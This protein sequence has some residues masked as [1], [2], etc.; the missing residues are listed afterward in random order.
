MRILGL[1]KLT[2]ATLVMAMGSVPA[3]AQERAGAEVT[4]GTIDEVVVTAQ[5]REERLLDVPISISVI[6]GEALDQ[7]SA[8]GANEIL[9]RIPGVAAVEGYSAGGTLVTVRGV[10]GGSALANGSSPI[11][12]YLDDVPFGLV[13]SAIAPD[14]SVFDLDRMEV[15]RGPQGTLY[16]ASAQNG[17]VR[18]LTH[19]PDL[20]GFDLKARV[21]ASSTESGGWNQ[22]GD[23]AANVPIVAGKVA[24]RAVVSYQDLSGWID[25]PNRRDA[26]SAD[27]TTAR[28]K[29]RAA[30]TERLTVDLSGWLSRSDYEAPAFSADGRINPYPAD[31][32]IA[33]DYDVI[34]AKLTYEA[35]HF[36]VTSAT[37]YLDYTNDS[38]NEYFGVL[39]NADC[40]ATPER[41]QTLRTR[42]DSRIYNQDISVSSL[43]EG[44]LSWTAGATYRDGKDRLLQNRSGYTA[45]TILN[46]F[47]KSIAAFGELTGHFMEGKLDLTGGLRY[48]HDDVTNREDSRTTGATDLITSDDKFEKVTPRAVISY[49]PY[50]GATIYASYSEGF[51]SGFPQNG[52]VIASYPQFAPLKADTLHNY[53]IGTKATVWGGL[54]SFELAGFYIDWR[55][56][57]QTL[58]VTIPG[59]ANVS[60]LVNGESASGYGV[61]AL[62]S[63]NPAKGLTISGT[64]SWNGLEQDADI[65]SS[66]LVLF[67]KGS[68]LLGS[69]EYTAS[70]ALDYEFPLGASGFRGEFSASANYTSS[71]P[72]RA[73]FG[74]AVRVAESEEILMG[75][76]SFALQWPEQWRTSLFVDN[77]SN[78][79]GAVSVSPLS[80][81][82][83]VRPRP[84]T[85]GLQ[86]DYRF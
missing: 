24:A 27:I 37:S 5:R 12:Y 64:V 51:R 77:I 81:Q 22:R 62:A 3:Q 56:V 35:D 84:R 30:A 53:E 67:P 42:L 40:V 47:T 66:G 38:V 23:L 36:V 74:T 54:A 13:K 63:V 15:L 16:G 76:V 60:A 70:A 20:D 85:T 58:G 4:D 7:S 69:P 59:G 80:P 19:N 79:Q 9:S 8:R 65:V 68:R 55:D 72:Y 34:G 75:R 45:P 14:A 17:V 29:L 6:G 82:W 49:H 31:E 11:A 57:Q 26:N 78:E 10:N 50:Q 43:G 2:G 18:V 86:L 39:L 44:M 28:L 21:A 41:C 1:S 46:D 83:S 33:V 52:N 61:E 25:K 71:L 48:F 32:G 73:L